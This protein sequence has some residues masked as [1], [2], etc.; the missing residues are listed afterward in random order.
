[1]LE[2]DRRAVREVEAEPER[3]LEVLEAAVDYAAWSSLIEGVEVLGEGRVRMQVE[4]FGR[5][6]VMD[7][8]LALDPTGALLERLPN[9]DGDEERY[10]ASWKVAPGAGGGS[11]SAEV[12][13]HVAAALEAP[14]PARL[15]RGRIE[16]RLVDDLLDDFAREAA[17]G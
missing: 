3:C 14:G 12:T 2:I 9:D 13:L 1:M 10:L 15:L 4:L 16:K 5:H 7:C 11:S 17:P 6:V 8:R